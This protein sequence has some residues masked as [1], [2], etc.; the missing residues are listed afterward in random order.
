MGRP[1]VAHILVAAYMIRLPLGG[2]LSYHLHLLLALKRL[3]HDVYLI[4][5]AV[6][7]GECWDPASDAMG[8]DASTGMT[9]VSDL[10]SRYGLGDRWAFVDHRGATYGVPRHELEWQLSHADL[11]L[12]VG[13][14][15][16]W[17]EASGA[18]AR[19]LLDGEPG[20]TQM[21]WAQR[22]SAGAIL[23]QYDAYF[24][25]GQNVGRPGNGIPTLG[26]QWRSTYYPIV[27]DLLPQR[28][29]PTRGPFTTV[30][31]WQA[32]S[33]VNFEGV[34]YGQKD[35]EFARFEALPRRVSARLEV[36]A[37]GRVPRSRLTASG[38]I[39]RNAHAVT[40]DL[41]S[42]WRYI[43]SSRG[44]F[45]V[46]KHVFVA[47][48]S[49]WF[50]ERSSLYLGFGRPVVVQDTG[51]REHLPDNQGIVRFRD[52]EEAAD[53]LADVEGRYND[54]ARWAREIACE[55]FDGSRVLPALLGAVG[56]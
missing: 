53:A 55:Y 47:T 17:N 33:V 15:G 37:A 12:D 38:W 34:E 25:V 20:W 45:S 11:L 48:R 3:G 26:L 39:V 56:I 42:Y 52:P 40:A 4:E 2:F 6:G 50:S 9:I 31:N 22:A 13:A 14:H 29:A 36:A 24:T 41:G 10:L 51:L 1:D 32:H 7:P 19:V 16:S 54:H 8:D 21:R 43:Q 23:P 46:A 5:R 35:R 18:R 28:P 30:M 49:G 27:A 44:E